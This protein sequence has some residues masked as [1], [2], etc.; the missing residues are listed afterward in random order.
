LFGGYT[1]AFSP[2]VQVF[3]P[4]TG[5]VRAAGTLPMGVAD[6]KFR[7]IGKRWYT[8][9][10]EVGVRIRGRHTWEGVSDHEA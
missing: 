10:G 8:V 2:Q 9:G 7:R 1:D 3:D 5:A 4:H 6:A